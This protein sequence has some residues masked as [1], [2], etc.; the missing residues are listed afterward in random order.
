MRL[1]TWVLVSAVGLVSCPGLAQQVS[2]D[3]VVESTSG[4]FKFPDGTVQTT[5]SGPFGPAHLVIVAKS[6]GDYATIQAALDSIADASGANPYLVHVAPGVFAERVT[7]KPWVDIEGSGQNAT[8]ISAAGSSSSDPTV[9]GAD[10]AEMRN[11]TV[12]NTGGASQAQG[13]QC[14]GTSPTF[15][16]ITVLAAGGTS[17]TRAVLNLNGASPIFEDIQAMAQGPMSVLAIETVDSSAVLDRARVDASGPFDNSALRF[18][19]STGSLFDV[20]ATS[21]GNGSNAGLEALASSDLEA[22]GVRAVASGSGSNVGVQLSSSTGI[23]FDTVATSTG[24]GS[25]TGIEALASS[26]L[27]ARGV[28]AV[29]TGS[30]S[31]VGVHSETSSF[32][33]EYLSVLAEGQTANNTRGVWVSGGSALFDHASIRAQ[34]GDAAAAL[35]VTGATTSVL[36]RNS[37][38]EAQGGTSSNRGIDAAGD[39]IEVQG[40]QVVGATAS[41]EATGSITIRVGGSLLGGGAVVPG[42]GTITCAGVYD[43]SYVFSASSCP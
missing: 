33:S 25:N 41:I 16:H 5:A 4:G 20:V 29:A 32:E 31:N 37:S 30:G 11:L 10:N 3:G 13:I 24:S 35:Y 22:R 14:D 36:V 12:A 38:V 19:S 40:S 1:R 21:T 18:S 42:G 23:L 2:V 43:E 28:R 9:L 8:V 17:E 26:G 34:A 15:R 39:G 6:G 7:M 27:E